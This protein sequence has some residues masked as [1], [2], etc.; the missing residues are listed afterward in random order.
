MADPDTNYLTNREIGDEFF[1]GETV[2]GD[3]TISEDRNLTHKGRVDRVI[4]RYLRVTTNQTDTYGDIKEIAFRLYG[5]ILNG[6][7]PKLND[8]DKLQLERAGFVNP[9]LV[10]QRLDDFDEPDPV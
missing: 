7:T 6:I 8:D 10:M 4:N 1:N 5:D 3:N 2:P 9:P